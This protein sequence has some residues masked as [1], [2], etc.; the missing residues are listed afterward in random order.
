MGKASMNMCQWASNDKYI[1]SKINVEDKCTDKVIKVLGMIW[2]LDVD[3][4]YIS[5]I[6]M[7]TN[8]DKL[9]KRKMLQILAAIYDPLGLLCP[10]MIKPKL[11]IQELWK[12]RIGWDE[13][14]P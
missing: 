6:K 11:P 5:E 14:V 9:S 12:E 7:P 1:M 4:L 2:K 3:K 13:K 8:V 10:V